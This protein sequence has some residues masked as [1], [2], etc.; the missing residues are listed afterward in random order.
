MYIRIFQYHPLIGKH[1]EDPMLIS[2]ISMN[3]TFREITDVYK[4]QQ[5]R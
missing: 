4:H 1:F 3:S 2:L 5:K